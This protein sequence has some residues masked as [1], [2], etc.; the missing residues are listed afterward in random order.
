[1]KHAPAPSGSLP[2][3]FASVGLNLSDFEMNSN[4]SEPMTKLYKLLTGNS[5]A[6]HAR[7]HSSLQKLAL[8]PPS[9]NKEMKGK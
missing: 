7:E 6:R 5:D 2:S 9:Q 1:M 8:T 4:T 3:V